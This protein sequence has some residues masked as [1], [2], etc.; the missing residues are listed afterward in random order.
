MRT[1]CAFV[2]S[3]AP[4]GRNLESITQLMEGEELVAQLVDCSCCRLA[5]PGHINWTRWCVLVIWTL[6]KWSQD[7]QRFKD[8]SAADYQV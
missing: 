8:I 7:H 2:L 1:A 6:G 5:P 3:G 4:V